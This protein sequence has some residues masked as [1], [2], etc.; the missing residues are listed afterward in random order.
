M[1]A[2]NKSC[3]FVFFKEKPDRNVYS[4]RQVAEAELEQ[5]DR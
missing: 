1:T 5:H 4:K 2:Q 3:L